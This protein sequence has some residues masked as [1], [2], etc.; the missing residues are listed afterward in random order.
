MTTDP[1]SSRII[2]GLPLSVPE[3]HSWDYFEA[4]VLPFAGDWESIMRWAHNEQT[5]LGIRGLCLWTPHVPD[6][7]P[8]E[9][10]RQRLEWREDA[11]YAGSRLSRADEL[12]NA[13]AWY[14]QQRPT[15]PM[16]I[17]A[18]SP[19]IRC[20]LMTDPEYVRAVLR[21]NLG[22]LID[23]LMIAGPPAA[24]IYDTV[25]DYAIHYQV[26]TVSRPLLSATRELWPGLPVGGEPLGTG[27]FLQLDTFLAT[28]AAWNIVRG[29]TRPR[30]PGLVFWSTPGP[31]LDGGIDDVRAVIAEGAIAVVQSHQVRESTAGWSELVSEQAS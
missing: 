31:E 20:P 21:Y 19:N 17:Y 28:R 3:G 16:Y 27:R 6:M 24:L 15:D 1:R 22:P 12:S 25:G 5:R 11:A 18:G 4:G 8:G 13:M 9:T 2:L 29:R 30:L 10:W 26:R 23:S 7:R 14:R